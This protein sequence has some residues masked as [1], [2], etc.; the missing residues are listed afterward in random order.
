MNEKIYKTMSR[1]GGGT[2]ALG[3]VILVTGV[4]AGTLLIINGAKLIKQK[5]E[6]M[7]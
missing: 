3:I 6:I 5:Y 4:A 7:I 2:L 1:V